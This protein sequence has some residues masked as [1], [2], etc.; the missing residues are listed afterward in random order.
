MK[1]D[2]KLY[3]GHLNDQE[4]VVYGHVFKS[5]APDK[6][7]VDRRGHQ[8]CFLDYKY[9]SHLAFAQC[10]G[11]PC[12]L[13][14]L[15]VQTKTLNDGYFRFSIPYCEPLESGW[16]EYEIVCQLGEFGIVEKEEVLKPFKSKYGIISDIDDTFLISHSN[17]FFQKAICDAAEEHQKEKDF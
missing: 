2:L 7:R 12:I 6:Y 5:W 4:L 16:H 3:R 13:R 14:G 17:N 1:L 11:H 9:V 10:Q 8:A 15:E